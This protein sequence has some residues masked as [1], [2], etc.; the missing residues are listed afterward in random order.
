MPSNTAV[1]RE[2][3]NA[4]LNDETLT[5]LCYDYFR[6]VYN[7][8]ATGMSR[9]DK[10]QRLIAHCER[11]DS[12]GLL[13]EQI[14][15]LAPAQYATY[16]QQGR[17]PPPSTPSPPAPPRP[18]TNP[19]FYGGAVPPA[20]F[21][22]RQDIV[23]AV[24]QRVG[25]Q[26]AQSISIVGERRMGKSSLLA[27]IKARAADCFNADLNMLLISLDLTRG[28]CHT[29]RGL[30]RY[31]RREL[32]RAWRDPWPAAE[33]GD[34]A[35]FDFALEDLNNDGIRLLLCLD[36]VENLTQR[37][38]EFND[39]LEDWRACG[40]HGQLAMITASAQPLADLCA[41]GGL[42]SPFYNIFEQRRLRLLDRAEWQALVT[43]HM[44]ATAEELTFIERVAGG[45]PFFTQM[46]AGYLW[47]AQANGR[48][49]YE[50]VYREL[51]NQ[52]EPHL[53]HLWAKLNPTEQAVLRRLAT[54]AATASPQPRH[55]AALTRRGLLRDGQPFS[56]LFA[57]LISEQFTR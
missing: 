38:A 54:G 42:T 2:L 57:E 47:Q 51:Q 37:A 39:V 26:T 14:E 20:L 11:H 35:A 43:G 17:V 29:R 10:I 55:L 13:L 28:Y 46:A 31:L 3:L 12:F 34:L 18:A 56:P 5:A 41:T 9:P 32:T 23:A 21:Y 8:F 36:E 33:D 22:G 45:Q 30:M 1:I 53:R 25:G 4:A 16:A 44:A 27:Y 40:S 6:P 7:Q 52:I 49:D 24:V 50:A 15:R 19:F 48:P